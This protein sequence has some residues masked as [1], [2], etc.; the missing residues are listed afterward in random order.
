[1]EYYAALHLYMQSMV[2]IILRPLATIF[3]WITAVRNVAYDRGWLK[4]FEFT[5]PVIVVGNLKVGGTGKTPMVEYITRALIGSNRR[6][7]IISRGYKRKTKGFVLADEQANARTIGDEPYQYY[8]KWQHEVAVAVGEDRA[9]AIPHLLYERPETDV[10]VLDDAFQHRRV[11]PQFVVMLTEYSHP[12]FHDWVLP[13]G[14]LRESRHHARRSDAIVVTKCPADIT[15]QLQQQFITAIRRYAPHCPVYFTRVQYAGIRG[16]FDDTIK[17]VLDGPYIVVTGIANA[18]PM[19]NYLRSKGEVVKHLAF[20]DHHTYTSGDI[21]RIVKLMNTHK[22]LVLVTTEKDAV[23]L[24][25]FED[26]LGG[27]SCRYLPIAVK[28][29]DKENEFLDQLQKSIVLSD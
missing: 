14:L 4:S 7:G 23:K 10:I 22:D 29:I 28:F 6:V 13:A 18:Q 5:L 16:L 26:M 1:M 21:D 8:R 2:T 24:R 15:A 17:T 3:G 19:V 25:A 9:L 11:V 12:F 27:F 20:Q